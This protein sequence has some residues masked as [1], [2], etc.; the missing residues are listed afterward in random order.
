MAKNLPVA[1]VVSWDAQNI[2]IHCLIAAAPT[3][4]E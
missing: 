3:G 1:D 4:I 2:L